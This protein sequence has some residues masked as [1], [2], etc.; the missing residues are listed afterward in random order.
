MRLQGRLSHW[1]DDKG[2][3]FV[4][5]NGGGDRAFVHIKAFERAGRRPVEGDVLT[6]A[7]TRDTQG[8]L[9]AMAIRFAD[10]PLRLE[11]APSRSVRPPPART[12]AA[13]SLPARATA[14]RRGATSEA[15]SRGTFV[16]MLVGGFALA[17]ARLIATGH[18]PVHAGTLSVVMSLG[19]LWAYRSDKRAAAEGRWRTPES[20]LHLLAL[21]GGWPG[22]L[23]AQRWF[24][25]KSK[26]A[27]F[28]WMFR[29]TVIANVVALGWYAG[30]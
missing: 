30:R 14:M 23:L 20:S 12:T 7:T 21:C 9:Q 5:P 24:R 19:A 28:Q 2:F 10:E 13:R 25:H 6:Y 11:P 22:A 16:Y 17:L 26:K 27:E 1:N 4:V 29:F 8:R 18:L 3:G 15:P